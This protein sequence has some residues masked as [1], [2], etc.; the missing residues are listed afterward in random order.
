MRGGL[1]HGQMIKS[2]CVLQDFVPFR[3]AAQKKEKEKKKKQG[4][5]GISPEFLQTTFIIDRPTN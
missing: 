4:Q 5:Q 3:A 2:P 1:T